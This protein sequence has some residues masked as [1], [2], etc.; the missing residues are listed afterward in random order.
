MSEGTVRTVIQSEAS[1]FLCPETC[2]CSEPGSLRCLV[3][4]SVSLF[5]SSLILNTSGHQS[6]RKQR[7]HPWGWGRKGLGVC[8]RVPESRLGRNGFIWLTCSAITEG[9]Q[10]GTQTR[11]TVGGRSWCRGRGGVLLIGLLP[12]GL[13]ILLSYRTQDHQPRDGN[14]YSGLGPP[15]SITN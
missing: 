11:Q 5:L 6:P 9:S 4:S 1:D 14:A 3:F 2:T 8:A 13:L 7:R 12:H 15:T 10:A